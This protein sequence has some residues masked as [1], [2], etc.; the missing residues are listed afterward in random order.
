M[1]PAATGAEDSLLQNPIAPGTTQRIP[2]HDG[3][4]DMVVRREILKS[5]LTPAQICYRSLQKPKYAAAQYNKQ[6]HT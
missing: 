4:I 3:N 2:V 1:S 6:F 5:F